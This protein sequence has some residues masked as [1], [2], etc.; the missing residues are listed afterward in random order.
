MAI[1]VYSDLTKQVQLE[2]ATSFISSGSDTRFTALHSVEEVYYNFFRTRDFSLSENTVFFHTA[3]P[4]DTVV[5]LLPKNCLTAHLQANVVSNTVVSLVIDS[6]VDFTVINLNSASEELGG[7]LL[8]TDG[9]SFSP[10]I[11]LTA[12]NN[13]VIYLKAEVVTPYDIIKNIPHNK[14][15]FIESTTPINSNGKVTISFSPLAGETGGVEI[16]EL[17]I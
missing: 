12:G 2:E 6:D 11:S 8:S 4:K 16:Y 17:L 13:I 15:V 5:T 14:L 9:V 3:P 1:L 10:C 7:L